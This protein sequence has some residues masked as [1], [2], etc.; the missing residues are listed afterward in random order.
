MIWYGTVGVNL[1]R[2]GLGLMSQVWFQIQLRRCLQ[3]ATSSTIKMATTKSTKQ[4]GRKVF[5]VACCIY[6]PIAN[7]QVIKFAG[8]CVSFVDWNRRH[9]RVDICCGY[10]Y[11]QANCSK[12]RTF[13]AQTDNFY[14]LLYY[15]GFNIILTYL[16]WMKGNSVS[17]FYWLNSAKS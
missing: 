13:K 12:Q 9:T 1:H 4:R 15:I 14:I 6:R 7:R 2:S 3:C 10:D 5:A 16:S 17:I 8:L 11:I